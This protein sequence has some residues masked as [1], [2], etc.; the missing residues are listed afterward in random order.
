MLRWWS[1]VVSPL[2]CRGGSPLCF[3]IF[4][5]YTTGS[6]RI[7][8]VSWISRYIRALLLKIPSQDARAVSPPAAA[9]IL[10][11][12][13]NE[14][15]GREAGAE[16]HCVFSGGSI[17]RAP[18]CISGAVSFPRRLFSFFLCAEVLR[19]QSAAL[20]TEAVRATVCALPHV[21]FRSRSTLNINTKMDG[22]HIFATHTHRKKDEA[23]WKWKR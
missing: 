10:K 19:N 6:R 2:F 23:E 17:Q 12:N 11:W 21:G 14:K 22:A 13:R 3:L 18:T 20:E 16:R 7:L 15:Y 9:G 5:C 1:D 4:C 8:R